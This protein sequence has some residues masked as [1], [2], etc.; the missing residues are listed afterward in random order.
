MS[1]PHASTVP[2]TP[3]SPDS[4]VT[5][6]LGSIV[7]VWFVVNAALGF[8][9]FFSDH[10]RVIFLFVLTP[11]AAFVVAFALSPSLRA[12][13]FAVDTRALVF[14]QAVRT[15]GIAFLSLY[16]VGGLNGAFALWAGLIDAATGASAP[17]AAQYLTPTRTA[18]QRRRL[19]AWMAA[20]ILDF[21]VA[22]PLAA[23]VRAA[24]PSS[25]AALSVPPLSMITTFAVPVACIAYFILGAHLW[26]QRGRG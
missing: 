7:S 21:V 17:F 9:G 10:T 15:G 3:A 20:G 23:I 18:R 16:A 19:I 6:T 2:H 12:W 4:A 1:T 25:M 5:W 26:R 8:S 14:F 24:D 22:M 11:I 13:A